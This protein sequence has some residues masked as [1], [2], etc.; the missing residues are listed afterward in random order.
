MDLG[1]AGIARETGEIDPPLPGDRMA[2]IGLVG[3]VLDHEMDQVF[4][5]RLGDGHQ[6]AEIHQKAAVAVEHDDPAVG[7]PDGE[8]EGV[9]GGLPH[10]A[11]ADEVERARV[12]RHP[13]EGRRIGRH[14][15]GAAAVLGEFAEAFVAAHHRSILRP[16]SA[17]TG[18]DSA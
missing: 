6:A 18:R 7:Q 12:D 9:R 16:I 8:A 11:D 14:H 15:D 4:R 13:L 5:P 1:V 2:A 17:T 10:R 3:A